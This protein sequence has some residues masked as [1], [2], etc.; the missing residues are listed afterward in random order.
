VIAK[1]SGVVPELR[2]CSMHI[3]RKISLNEQK[4]RQHASRVTL[5]VRKLP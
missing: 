4:Q 3:L 5:G 1:V 2:D